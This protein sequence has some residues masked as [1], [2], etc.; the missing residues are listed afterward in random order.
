VSVKYGDGTQG[1]EKSK[2][3]REA[4]SASDRA[5]RRKHISVPAGVTFHKC[6]DT[7]DKRG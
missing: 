2:V 7:D 5:H 6:S 1:T 4:A 3:S